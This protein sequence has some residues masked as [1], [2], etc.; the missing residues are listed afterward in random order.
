MSFIIDADLVQSTH[1]EQHRAGN[2]SQCCR[3]LGKLPLSLRD[4]LY[5]AELRG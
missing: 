1:A 2:L 3:R 5:G 4:G